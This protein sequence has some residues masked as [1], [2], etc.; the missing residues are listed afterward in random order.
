MPCSHTLQ[1]R[2]RPAD[3]SG[4]RPAQSRL[5]RITLIMC[6]LH[7][8]AALVGNTRADWEAVIGRPM[9]SPHVTG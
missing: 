4:T 6:L 3:G 9:I 5:E 1:T 2:C 8:G 7:R